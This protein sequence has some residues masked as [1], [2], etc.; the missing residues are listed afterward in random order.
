[1]SSLSSTTLDLSSNISSIS[2]SPQ[3]NRT[4]SLAPPSPAQPSPAQF[5]LALPSLEQP[6]P[7]QPS[8]VQS[9]QPDLADSGPLVWLMCIAN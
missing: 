3:T 5:S 4:P 6:S 2:L 7:V 1:M 9:S 8:L